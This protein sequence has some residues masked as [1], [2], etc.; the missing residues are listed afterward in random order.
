MEIPEVNRGPLDISEGNLQDK[1][2]EE[3]EEENPFHN[4]RYPEN[5]DH[6]ELE[7]SDGYHNTHQE[8]SHLFAIKDLGSLRYFLRV[9]VKPFSS[10]IFFSQTKYTKDLHRARMIESSPL[11]TPMVIKEKATTSDH[12]PVDVTSYQ[13]IVGALQ[14]LTFTQPADIIHA[15]NRVCQ[16]FNSPTLVH[17]KAVKQI[18]RYFKGTQHYGVS[19]LA[20]SPISFYGFCDA[21]WAGCPTTR[22][23]TTEFCTFLGANCISWCSKKQP[24]VA[25]SSSEAEYQ[26]MASTTAEITWLTFLL[27][28]IGI[29]LFKP[30][31]LFCDNVSGL[32]MSVN[33]MFHARSKHI[34]CDYHFVSEKVAMGNLITRY[35]SSASQPANIFTKPLPNDSFS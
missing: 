32:H 13:S 27:Q 20:K 21:G 31:Q 3:E 17:L 4:A 14:Y 35:I 29:S 18:L 28:D 34:K 22:R 8:V 12:D 24:T 5:L 33:P 11:N 19:Y 30:P 15:V 7:E 2:F 16:N 23:S 1:Y 26:S 25:R 10:G 9:E 6:G